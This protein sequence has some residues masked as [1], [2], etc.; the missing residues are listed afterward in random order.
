MVAVTYF[1][2]IGFDSCSIS[3]TIT[4]W[5]AMSFLKNREFR[6]SEANDVTSFGA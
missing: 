5:F 2:K 1:V 6:P 3:V 4:S